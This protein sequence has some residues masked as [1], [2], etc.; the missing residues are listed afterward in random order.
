MLTTVSPKDMN[1]AFLRYAVSHSCA[2]VAGDKDRDSEPS[3]KIQGPPGGGGSAVRTS[4]VC[5]QQPSGNIR[6]SEGF[7]LQ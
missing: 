4:Q 6:D 2:G 1:P 7:L 5:G 3:L